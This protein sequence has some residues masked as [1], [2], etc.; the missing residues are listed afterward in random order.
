MKE[1]IT[2]RKLLEKIMKESISRGASDIHLDPSPQGLCVRIRRHGSLEN[3]EQLPANVHQE[4]ISCI[5]ILARL[6]TDIHHASQDGRYEILTSD[7]AYD[8]RV[9]IIPTLYGENAVLRLLKRET[10][11][12]S[13]LSLGFDAVS[14]SLIESSLRRSSGLV[15]VSGPTGSGKTTT[16]HSM[17]RSISNSERNVITLEDPIE[18]ILEGAR[19]IQ[20]NSDTG[21]SFEGMLRGIVRQ[22]PDVVMV[23]EIRD[24]ETAMSVMQMAMTGHLV[25]STLHAASALG[26]VARIK[27]IGIKP[28]FIGSAV[29]LIIHQKLVKKLCLH[30]RYEIELSLEDCEL[31][32]KIRGPT[33][34]MTLAFQSSGCTACENRGFDGRVC[35]GETLFVTKKLRQMIIAG[36]GEQEL[37]VEAEKSNFKTIEGE[38]INLIQRGVISLE[39]AKKELLQ[40]Q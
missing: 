3:M 30:C 1:E 20:L 24:K 8:V 33:E 22:D 40:I 11:P 21:V 15:I 4:I 37:L 18:Y 38:A 2:V 7:E 9:S 10:I 25:F 17:L 39:T 13:L 35:V 12:S 27:D 14:V 31:L 29:S 6:R 26:I 34:K 28:Y 16:L 36:A 5:K 19:Q 32:E 23:G